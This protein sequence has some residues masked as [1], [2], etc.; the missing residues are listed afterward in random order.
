ML[1]KELPIKIHGIIVRKVTFVT[2]NM[3]SSEA[4]SIECSAL[5]VAHL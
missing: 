4:F 5:K 1:S 2:K 3:K